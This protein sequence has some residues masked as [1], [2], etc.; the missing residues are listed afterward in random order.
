VCGD[1]DLSSEKSGKEVMLVLLQHDRTNNDGIE[2][3]L[4]NGA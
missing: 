1:P 4:D 2:D 3:A